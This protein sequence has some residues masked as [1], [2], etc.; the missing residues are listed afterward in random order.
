[1][2]NNI[3]LIGFMGSGKSTIGKSLAKALQFSFVDT[4]QELE[5]NEGRTITKIFNESGE[6]YFRKSEKKLLKNLLRQRNHVIATGGGMPCYFDNLKKM[7]ENGV[8]VFLHTSF[9]TTYGRVKNQKNRPMVSR[10]NKE[11]LKALYNLRK[12]CYFQAHFRVLA[13]RQTDLIVKRIV[14]LIKN[15]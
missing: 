5:K 10:M 4:D 11:E 15:I 6:A 12:V 3:Y 1:M 2:A 7:K 14:H 13:T 8:V 9:E